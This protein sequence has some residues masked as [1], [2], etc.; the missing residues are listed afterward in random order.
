MFSWRI[1]L[2]VSAGRK[3]EEM[4][5]ENRVAARTRG[6]DHLRLFFPRKLSHTHASGPSSITSVAS[7][8]SLV[9]TASQLLPSLTSHHTLFTIHSDLLQRGWLDSKQGLPS[10]SPRYAIM[11]IS[12]TPTCTYT[13]NSP[14]SQNCH[15]PYP[16]VGFGLTTINDGLR[17][18]VSLCKH[19][20]SL[21][22]HGCIAVLTW[23]RVLAAM[24]LYQLRQE[25]SSRLFRESVL[26]KRRSSF[27]F[28]FV[29]SEGS[30]N[31]VSEHA[32]H[33]FDMDTTNDTP[34]IDV[35]LTPPPTPSLSPRRPPVNRYPSAWRLS[36][37]ESILE[38]KAAIKQGKEASVTTSEINSSEYAA[39]IMNDR[40]FRSTAAEVAFCFSMGLTQLL[41]V[42][43]FTS[44]AS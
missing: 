14:L 34:N 3:R 38:Y 5:D 32:Q 23:G 10:R 44:T 9:V 36:S 16:C 18:E 30:S 21:R 43:I 4:F 15:Q 12:Q 8:T 39:S 27:I 40:R 19:R 17:T 41:A 31:M 1:V 29:T 7:D 26:L 2:A 6:A 20:H 42:S 25:S 11:Y 33:T 24:Q 13:P 22:H 37:L 28:S 35:P